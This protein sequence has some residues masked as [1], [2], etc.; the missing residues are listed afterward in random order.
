MPGLT[1]VW[2]L[3]NGNIKHFVVSPASFG[4]PAHPLAH[5]G[6]H[7]SSENAAILLRMLSSAEATLFNK[8]LAS[9][10]ALAAAESGGRE[11]PPIPAGTHL[12]AVADYTLLQAAALLYVAGRDESLPA[13]VELAR[14]SMRSG[15][16]RAALE[17]L[18]EASN[19]AV[20][21]EEKRLVGQ[22][23]KHQKKMKVRQ[24]S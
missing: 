8:P 1:Q 3:R 5:V 24:A 14:T 2:E 17:S 12:R 4:L 20:L 11:L 21:E 13:C 22:N 7:S 23:G 18:R 10:S 19:H 15:G 16:A 6:S 9:P